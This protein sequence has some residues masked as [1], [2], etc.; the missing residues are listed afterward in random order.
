MARPREC[1]TLTR[2]ARVPVLTVAGDDTLAAERSRRAPEP[3]GPRTWDLKKE[4]GP[5]AAEGRRPQ[6][7]KRGG[8]DAVVWEG[9]GFFPAAGR[10]LEFLILRQRDFLLGI[11]FWRS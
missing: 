10:G 9:A 3:G 4:K 6:E 7:R 5:G 8:G 11:S 1:R 2:E